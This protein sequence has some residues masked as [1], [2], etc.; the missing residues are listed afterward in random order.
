M[1]VTGQERDAHSSAQGVFL[2]S[3]DERIALP[4]EKFCELKIAI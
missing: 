1:D 3:L 2:K 4:L